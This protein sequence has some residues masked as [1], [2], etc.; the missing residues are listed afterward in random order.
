M[1]IVFDGQIAAKHKHGLSGAVDE[2][3]NELKKSQQE[4]ISPKSDLK[5]YRLGD[6]K[7]MAKQLE[8]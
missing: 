8:M 3:L 5:T 4:K 6:A 2:V 1:V 7:R